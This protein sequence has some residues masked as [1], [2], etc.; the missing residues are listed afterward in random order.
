MGLERFHLVG[1]SVGA[2]IAA[3]IAYAAPK[4]VSS[5]TLIEPFGVRVPYESELDKMLAQ[6]RNPMVIATEMAYD[7]LLGFV[8]HQPPEMPPALKKLRAEQASANRVFHLKVWKEVREGERAHLLDLL[9]PV[10]KITTLI[11]QGAESKVIHPATAGVIEAMMSDA[12]SAVIEQCGHFA[13][14]ERPQETAESILRFL[15]GLAAKA[16]G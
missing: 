9:L 11:I 14:T 4:Q 5:L 8:Y 12:R 16:A 13:M 3:A 2:S 1:H 6:D 7:N 10:I 15:G